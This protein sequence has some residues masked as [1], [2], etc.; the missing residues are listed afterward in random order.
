MTSGGRQDLRGVR[1][2]GS[3]DTVPL[4]VDLDG[5]LI[6]GDSL[7]ESFFALAKVNFIGFLAAAAAVRKGRAALKAAVSKRFAPEYEDFC[8]NPAVVGFARGEASGRPVILATAANERLA[9]IVADGLGYVSVVI[10]SGKEN[11]KSGAKLNAIQACLAER[12]WGD[13]FDYIGD[14]PADRPIWA[15]ARGVY[16]VAKSDDEARELAAGPAVTRRFDRNTVGVSDVVTAMRPSTW[17]WALLPLVPFMLSGAGGLAAGTGA[18]IASLCLLLVSIAGFL[19]NDVLDIY[20]DRRSAKKR[21]RLFASGALNI[22]LGVCAAI[23]LAL[24]AIAVA[25]LALPRAAVAIIGLYP[26]CAFTYTLTPVG[27]RN[28]LSRLASALYAG[29]AIA[30]GAVSSNVP[31]ASEKTIAAMLGFAGLAG[32]LR[33]VRMRG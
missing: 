31:L 10:A 18:A 6:H 27:W 15:A 19:I 21:R 33:F 14:H 29:G 1:D 24:L 26:V 17:P 28:G 25:G 16:V 7:W 12:G 22:P 5:T 9:N 2:A 8:F 13:D 32:F 4:V 11:R 23:G 30:L 3:A 20:S